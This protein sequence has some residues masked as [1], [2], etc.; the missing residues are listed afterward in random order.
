MEA[1]FKNTF[2][3][4]ERAKGITGETLVAHLERRLDNAVYRLGFAG[5]RKEVRMMVTHGGFNVN[6]VSLTSRP[7]G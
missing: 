6:A 2:K 3:V 5:C 4:A 7:T 1:Q